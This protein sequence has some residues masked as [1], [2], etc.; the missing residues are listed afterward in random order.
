M[1][2]EFKILVSILTLLFASVFAMIMKQVSKTNAHQLMI[3]QLQGRLDGVEARTELAVRKVLE[4]H[5]EKEDKKFD[6]ILDKLEEVQSSL[7][8][9]FKG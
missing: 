2:E 8:R 6:H 4:S 1:S 3:S 5:E 7:L 9:G